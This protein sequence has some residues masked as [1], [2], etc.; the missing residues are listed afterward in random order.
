MKLKIYFQKPRQRLENLCLH[1]EKGSFYRGGFFLFHAYHF[2]PVAGLFHVSV[3]ISYVQAEAYSGQVTEGQLY[4]GEDEADDGDDWF[5][6]PLKFKRHIDDDLRTGS[7]GRKADDYSVID[8]LKKGSSSGGSGSGSGLGGGGR[9]AVWNN[10]RRNGTTG[11][12]GAMKMDRKRNGETKERDGKR[13]MDEAKGKH[14]T[15][16][17]EGTRD[18]DGT[19]VRDGMKE[20]YETREWDGTRKRDGTRERDGKKREKERERDR[21]EKRDTRGRRWRDGMDYSRRSQSRDR[22]R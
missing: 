22:R 14:G 11:N 5:A 10:T 7:D 8:P 19:R 2:S 9:D 15:R 6:G 20:K 13:R 1:Y 16:G 4:E 21:K 3:C 12:Y 17:W 18:D